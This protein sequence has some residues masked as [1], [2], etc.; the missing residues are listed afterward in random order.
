M[1]KR[2]K[3]AFLGL[4]AIKCSPFFGGLSCDIDF[5]KKKLK[6][7]SELSLASFETSQCNNFI[8]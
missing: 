6:P 3:D 2:F 5:N 8:V 1:V 4:K 7:V